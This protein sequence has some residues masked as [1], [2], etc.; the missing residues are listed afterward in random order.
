MSF[1]EL[2]MFVCLCLMFMPCVF[3]QNVHRVASGPTVRTVVCVRTVVSVTDRR[4]VVFVSRAGPENS[5]RTVREP[6]STTLSRHDSVLKR[7]L[8]E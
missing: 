8:Q 3:S 5:V 7:F 1:V 4:V 6:K 2:C